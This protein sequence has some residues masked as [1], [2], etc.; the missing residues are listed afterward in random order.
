[1]HLASPCA[2]NDARWG[3][4]GTRV[5]AWAANTYATGGLVGAL[6]RYGPDELPDGGDNDAGTAVL[7]DAGMRDFVIPDPARPGEVLLGPATFTQPHVVTALSDGGLDPVL[8][9]TAPQG[10]FGSEVLLSIDATPTSFTV[11]SQN[12]QSAEPRIW[13]APRGC[14]ASTCVNTLSATYPTICGVGRFGNVIRWCGLQIDPSGGSYL[15]VLLEADPDKGAVRI[16]NSSAVIPRGA[17]GS[18]VLP[19]F[20]LADTG[21]YY[22]RGVKIDLLPLAG[23][24]VPIALTTTK[25]L[26]LASDETRLYWAEVDAIYGVAR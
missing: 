4:D 14:D 1:V 18:P 11:V 6:L 3:T 20:V 15:L 10:L 16:I 12:A 25:P 22:A 17:N 5:Y 21:I 8:A 23:P 26:S 7:L 9:I 13:T 2:R 19:I 24:P